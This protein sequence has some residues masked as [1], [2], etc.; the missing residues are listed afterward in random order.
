MKIGFKSDPGMVRANN[1]DFIIIDEEIELYL[2]ADGVGGH[3]SGETASRLAAKTIHAC[4]KETIDTQIN[5]EI[6]QAI[7]ESFKI[8]HKVILSNS[9]IEE[10]N[11]GMATTVVMY[12]F[13]N[14]KVYVAHVGDSRAYVIN[15]HNLTQLTEDHSPVA[16][17]VRKGEI[18]KRSAKSHKMKHMVAQC[19][20]SDQYWGP[21]IK[22][23][24]VRNRDIF[25][26]CSDGLTDM[27]SDKEIQKVLN[28]KKDDLQKHADE[29]VGLANKRGGRDN[30][31]V[32]LIE[33]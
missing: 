25:L 2:I 7:R 26:L 28:K 11:K 29:L 17:L 14:S 12:L 6:E 23:L 32:I 9:S 10:E 21:D 3:Q 30:V 27:V 5:Y 1:E 18:S 4:L 13:Q 24:D 20:G 33:D 15:S 22:N 31:T 8:A 19:L 16:N